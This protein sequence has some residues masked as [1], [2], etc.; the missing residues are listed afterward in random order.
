MQLLHATTLFGPLYVFERF[1]VNFREPMPFSSQDFQ[2]HWNMAGCGIPQQWRPL[3]PH[4]RRALSITRYLVHHSPHSLTLGL[5]IRFRSSL[6]QVAESRI[7]KLRASLGVWSTNLYGPTWYAS[8]QLYSPFSSTCRTFVGIKSTHDTIT[9]VNR[10]RRNQT[11]YYQWRLARFSIT[12]TS[13]SLSWFALRGLALAHALPTSLSTIRGYGHPMQLKDWLL[14]HALH[15][16]L[17]AI[18]GWCSWC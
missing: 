13:L 6:A 8:L 2:F 12:K 16:S 1:P 3:C 11:Y 7:P 14:I 5:V 17:G 4:I 18:W 15:T 10:L 9:I